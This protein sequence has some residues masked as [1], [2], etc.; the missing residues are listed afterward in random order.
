MRGK[1]I[2]A[3]L[4]VVVILAGVGGYLYFSWKADQDRLRAEQAANAARSR[5]P[6]GPYVAPKPLTEAQLPAFLAQQAMI[7][8][9]PSGANIEIRTTS[10]VYTV[11]DKGISAGAATNPDMTVWLPTKYIAD[12]TTVGFC[13]TLQKGFKAGDIGIDVHGSKISLG[14]KYSGLLQYRSCIGA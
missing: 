8:D 5:G 4:L 7:K 1:Q 10:N 6:S 13:A 11:T 3:V 14:F 2:F 12:F 9:L